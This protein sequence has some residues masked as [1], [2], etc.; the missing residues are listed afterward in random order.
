M[1]KFDAEYGT[2][3]LSIGAIVLREIEALQGT[4]CARYALSNKKMPRNNP[5]R[6]VK[7]I[8]PGR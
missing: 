4:H 1:W 2:P 3:I 5:G 7:S 8:A 6:R